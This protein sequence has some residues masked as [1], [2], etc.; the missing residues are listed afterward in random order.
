MTGRDLSRAVVQEIAK[1]TMML[2][3]FAVGTLVLAFFGAG[4]ARSHDAAEGVRM[5]VES[6]FRDASES[7]PHGIFFTIHRA[8][9]SVTYSSWFRYGEINRHGDR[10][11]IGAAHSVE[12]WP[13][14]RSEWPEWTRKYA[15]H[16]I[17]V[18]PQG[19]DIAL[20]GVRKHEPPPPITGG[21]LI[22][23]YGFPAGVTNLR[24][25]EV[26]DGYVYLRRG[27]EEGSTWIV[28]FFDGEEAAVAGMS[29]GA[30]VYVT[31]GGAEVIIAVLTTRNSPADVDRD[32]DDEES[33]DVSQLRL[34][35][36]AL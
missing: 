2:V 26:R 21:M 3:I 10:G 27:G 9:D 6:T 28:V 24:H 16:E 1:V 25:F 13:E 36:D 23:V 7:N 22:R 11:V 4:T 34:G 8:G 5:P 30:V 31:E 14:D 18:R 32:G 17:T 33:S 12:A 20:F 15:D 35:A 19:Y 29:G